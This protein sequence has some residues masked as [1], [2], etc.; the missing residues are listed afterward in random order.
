MVWLLLSSFPPVSIQEKLVHN[1]TFQT[2]SKL[3]PKWRKDKDR[4]WWKNGFEKALTHPKW[5]IKM[6][7]LWQLQ[8]S[9]SIMRSFCPS[10]TDD[11]DYAGSWG[12]D[13]LKRFHVGS[14]ETNFTLT[15]SG[16]GHSINRKWDDIE[17]TFGVEFLT[18]D[19]DSELK[20]AARGGGG[21][22]FKV[23]SVYH[24]NGQTRTFG[25]KPARGSG[26]WFKVISLIFG[27]VD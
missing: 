5:I 20:C 6:E 7:F 9:C 22:W 1:A 10:E 24:L 3:K 12:V 27:C 17:D 16:Q 11:D 26:G 14:E 23:T 8:A 18:P 13:E 19:R 21:W 15:L 25:Q 2:Y 4:K